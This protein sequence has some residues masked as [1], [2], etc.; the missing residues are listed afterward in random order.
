MGTYIALKIMD[1]ERVIQ[2]Q[3]Q[4]IILNEKAV[5]MKLREHPFV[6]KLHYTI[7][8]ENTI[9]F[10]LE[11]CVGGE[12][13]NLLRQHR[14]MKEDQARF[15]FLEVLSV[16]HEAHRCGIVYRDLKPENIVIDHEGHVR[17]ADFGLSKFDFP[18]EN[19]ESFCGSA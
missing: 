12:L 8:T 2:N 5:L 15:Y 10:G 13:F 7:E 6:T 19:N 18:D 14:R 4:S 3:K 17:L 11:F 16:L 1:K 9:S